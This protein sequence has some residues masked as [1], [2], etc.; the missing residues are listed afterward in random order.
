MTSREAQVVRGLIAAA[1]VARQQG[2]SVESRRAE[3]E[4][5]E[6]QRQLESER[7]ATQLLRTISAELIPV[8]DVEAL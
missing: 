5:R 6:A 1:S 3:E 7:A 2:S 8:S 4:L